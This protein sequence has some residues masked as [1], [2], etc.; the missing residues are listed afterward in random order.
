MN[1][2][3]WWLAVA[4]VATVAGCK[5]KEEPKPAETPAEA[6]TGT[7]RSDVDHWGRSE[8]VR[9]ISR[10]IYEP[11][12]KYWFRAEWEGLEHLPREGGALLVSNQIGRAHV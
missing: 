4:C 1:S 7:R 2:Q 5:K 9:Q 3:K 11:I 10:R 6:F 12:Y 8:R